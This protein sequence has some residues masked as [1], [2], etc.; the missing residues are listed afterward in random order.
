MSLIWTWHVYWEKN[1]NLPTWT[2][3]IFFN[4]AL[5]DVWNLKC[6]F[7]SKLIMPRLWIINLK[8]SNFLHFFVYSAK[9]VTHSLWMWVFENLI[10]IL[11]CEK[12]AKKTFDYSTSR[13]IMGEHCHHQIFKVLKV[14][15][16]GASNVSQSHAMVTFI[17]N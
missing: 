12:N 13:W 17:A 5:F 10:Q 11:K 15:M 4:L 1:P 3:Y 9:L 2:T 7:Y 8:L 16:M 6:F 14:A